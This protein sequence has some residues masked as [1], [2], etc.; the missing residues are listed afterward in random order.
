MEKTLYRARYG[1]WIAGVCT[2]MAE[3]MDL[4]TYVV[5]LIF[6]GMSLFFGGGILVYIVS[7]FLIPPE[8]KLIDNTE[9]EKTEE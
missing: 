6:A 3:Y 7:I 5:R 2:G 9:T 1:K 8:P 4:P